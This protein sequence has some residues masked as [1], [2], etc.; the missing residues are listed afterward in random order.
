MRLY[1]PYLGVFVLGVVS[2][3]SVSRENPYEKLTKRNSSTAG[4]NLQ[5]DLGYE[6]YAGVANTITKVNS[7]KGIRFAAPPIG[8]LR[9][10]A[11]QAPV[12]NRSSVLAAN[13]FPAQCPQSPLATG[14]EIT[15]TVA[16]SLYSTED[17]LFLNVYAPAN[18]SN[19]P[20]LVWIHGGGYGEG[21]GQQDLTA[22]INANNNS[23]IGVSI[24]YRLGAFG[25]ISSDEVFKNGVVN[26]GLLDQQFALQWVQT[27]INLFGGDPTK[28]TVSG[29]SAGG[30]SVMLHTMAYGGSQGTSLFKNAIAASPY[31]PF[32]YGYKDWAPTQSYYAFADQ[33]GCSATAAYAGRN[34]SIFQCLSQKDTKVLQAASFNVSASGLFGTWGFLP[35]TDGVFI[36]QL[37]S[38][39][40]LQRQVNGVNFLSGNNANE[41]SVFVPSGINTEQDLVNWLED[42]FPMFTNNDIAKILLYY[43]SSNLTDNPNDPKYATLGYQGATAINE[44]QLATGQQQ[45]ADDIYAETTF[46]CPSYWLAEA[47]SDKSRSSYKYQYSV[48]IATHGADVSGY[49]GPANPTQSSDFEYAFMKIWGNFITKDNPSISSE[50]ANGVSSNQSQQTNPASAWPPFN[51]YAPYQLNLNETGGVPFALPEGAGNATVFLGPGLKN[52]FTLVNA[53][54]WE[55]GRG[56]RCD[57]WRSMGVSM[58]A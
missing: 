28:V 27:Y 45:R 29:E 34:S 24:Q 51:I 37:P 56:Y 23:F 46:V 5:V 32:Q 47:F 8:S 31:L 10:Q 48:P 15:P 13:A 44:S 1:L 11:P 41:G 20:V 21:N 22:I 33:A 19:L 40:L 30:G 49:F 18:A 2:A 53:Y 25:F 43:P 50:I 26:A 35:V 4:N 39:Q 52:D 36:Q 12:T 7:F 38:Q 58:P 55:G 57:F 3:A 16:A 42:T 54:S 17:C 14:T 6:I 9:W